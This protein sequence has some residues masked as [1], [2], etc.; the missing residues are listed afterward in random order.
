METEGASSLV[1]T[2]P[3]GEKAELSPMINF[4]LGMHDIEFLSDIAVGEHV[5]SAWVMF[6]AAQFGDGSLPE[7]NYSFSLKWFPVPRN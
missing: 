5:A 3:L 1:G 2:S 4:F 7:D 6:P